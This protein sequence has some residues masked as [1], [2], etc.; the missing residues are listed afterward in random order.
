MQLTE[1]QRDKTLPLTKFNDLAENK[2]PGPEFDYSLFVEDGDEAHS[3][4]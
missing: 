4:L 1:C 3:F 2:E